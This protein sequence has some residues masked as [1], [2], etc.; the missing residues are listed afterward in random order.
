MDHALRYSAFAL[1]WIAQIRD[2]FWMEHS[3]YTILVIL[4]YILFCV[5]KMVVR[6][7][8]LLNHYRMRNLKYGLGLG[9]VAFIF[10]LMS[11]DDVHDT[12]RFRHGVAQMFMG[13]AMYN[14]WKVVQV[15]KD[16]L[17]HNI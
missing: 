2:D 11:L 9:F 14:L 17:P 1:L 5:G 12:W 10:F 16:L 7:R 15:K 6:G 8:K 13:G 4:I 3:Q